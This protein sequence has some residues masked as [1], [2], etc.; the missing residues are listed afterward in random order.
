MTDYQMTAILYH[1]RDQDGG[2]DFKPKGGKPISYG[3]LAKMLAEKRGE[4][5]EAVKAR[6]Q[7]KEARRFG[8]VPEEE[9]KRRL[10]RAEKR[11]GRR[12]LN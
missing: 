7:Q 4:D 10:E 1:P 11:L 2:L 9:M 12:N 3:A 5:L 8:G 6:M